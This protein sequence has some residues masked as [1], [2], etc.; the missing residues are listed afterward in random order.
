M[1]YQTLEFESKNLDHLGII[2]PK[3]YSEKSTKQR[4]TIPHFAL[5]ISMLS[6]DSLDDCTRLA[7]DSELNGFSLSNPAIFAFSLSKV[8]LII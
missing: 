5:D 2:A 1:N 8:L 4:H 3:N 6:G 7:E